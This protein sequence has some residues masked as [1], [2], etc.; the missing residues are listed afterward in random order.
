MSTRK[1]RSNELP[2]VGDVVKCF[3]G[4]FGDAVITRSYTDAD[5]LPVYDIE[6]PH[7]IVR[8]GTLA[9]SV[10]RIDYVTLKSVRTNYEAYVR[11]TSDE[12]ENRS[13]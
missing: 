13:Y 6:R 8:L 2:K 12:I 4:S 1:Y 9:I 7:A 10:E 3:T 5:N 11:G